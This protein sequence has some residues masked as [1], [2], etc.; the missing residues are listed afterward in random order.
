MKMFAETG[1]GLYCV[2][3]Q[4]IPIGLCGLLKRD[5]LAHPDLGFAFLPKYRGQ[6]YALEAAR[7]VCEFAYETL[8][9]PEILAICSPSNVA[10]ANLLRNVGFINVGT[11]NLPDYGDSLLWNLLLPDMLE[12]LG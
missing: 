12:S 1:F 5:Y 11:V 3:L 10:S 2:E 6:G 7:A 4:E 9:L 8:N